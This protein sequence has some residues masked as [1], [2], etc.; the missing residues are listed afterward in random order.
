MAAHR[1]RGQST[2]FPA[3]FAGTAVL[4]G[5]LVATGLVGCTGPGSLF[6]EE[7]PN[8]TQWRAEAEAQCLAETPPKETATL[9][10]VDALEGPNGICGTEHP[11]EVTA[12]PVVG[13]ALSPAATLSCPMIPAL[14]RWMA[15][16]VQPA[17]EATFD[18]PVKRLNV[19]ASYVCRGR[20]NQKGARIS[21]HAFANAI[22][23]ASFE[24]ADGRT[25]TVTEGW[26]GKDDE[27]AFLRA[28]HKGSCEHFFTVIGPEGDDYHR[29]HF[30]LDL[31]R[32]AAKGGYRYCK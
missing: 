15:T 12:L 26:S 25:I 16:I 4:A 6:A 23:I 17:A 24:L 1:H 8:R 14:D 2:R 11:F 27:Q 30:H 20:N 7:D 29:T 32:R 3:T 19:A 31:A 13:T 28:V 10:A 21:E 22:D 9:K 5:L 18:Q